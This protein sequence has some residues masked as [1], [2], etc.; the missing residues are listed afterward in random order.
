[1]LL[2]LSK[3]KLLTVRIFF[4]HAAEQPPLTAQMQAA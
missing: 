4:A 3:I 2:H 1:M